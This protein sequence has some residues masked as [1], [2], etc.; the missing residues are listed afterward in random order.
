M[1]IEQKKAMSVLLW[2]Q[3][4]GAAAGLLAVSAV[5]SSEYLYILQVVDARA[6]LKI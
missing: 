2:R 5:K 6:A 4:R 1:V 3:R